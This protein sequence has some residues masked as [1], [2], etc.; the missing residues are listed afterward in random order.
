MIGLKVSV[1]ANT[2]PLLRTAKAGEIRSLDTA[3]AYTAGVVKR[4]IGKGS[5]PSA[6]GKP[7]H[8]RTGRLPRSIGFARTARS[9]HPSVVVG[10]SFSIF[11][12]LGRTHEQGGV[13]YAKQKK[14][15][16]AW[17]LRVGGLGPVR[18]EG[19]SVSLVH[20][21]RLRTLRQVE[22]AKQVARTLPAQA[23]RAQ[24]KPIRR[25]PPRPFM[26]PGLARAR[27]RIASF[28]KGQLR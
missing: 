13:E 15:R 25:Y 17:D 6:P 22:R 27:A 10:P 11:A 14:L 12:K 5:K 16:K 4:S 20:V 9:L 8:T 18:S 19:G 7:P 1:K 2:R 28:F 21:V 3:G 26:G 23:V 24:V